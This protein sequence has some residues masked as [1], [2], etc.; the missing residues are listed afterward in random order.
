MNVEYFIAKRIHFQQGKKNVSRPAVRI[1]TIGIAL[2]LAVMLISVCVVIGFKSQI[3]NKIIGFG[4]HI[5][6]TNFDNN[7]TY[8]MNPIKMDAA[9]IQKIRQIPGVV[10]VQRFAT[11]PGIIK[12]D[13]EFQGIILK[14][15]DKDFDWNFFRSNLLEGNILNVGSDSL[16]NEILLSKKLSDLLGLKLGDELFMYFIQDQVRARKF[17]I[18]GIYSTNFVDYDQLFVLTDI[19][20]VQRLNNWDSASFGGLEVLIDNFDK[21]DERGEA[22]YGATANIFSKDG[23]AYY[24][25]TIKQLNPQIFS[26]LDLLDMNVW[27][28]LLLM[29][30][31]AGF[32][33]ISGLLIL[34][35][36]RTNMIGILKSL[37]ATNWSVRKIF[38]YHSFFLIA[39]G[40]FW[41]NL[42]GLSICALQYF[43][44][45]IPLDPE[46]YYV[47]SVPVAFPWGYIVLLNIGTFV[48][49]ILMMIAPSYLITKI[50]PA[51][52]I[53]YE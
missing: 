30:S 24:T 40:M 6:I 9:L 15:I 44:G 13:N 3:E 46:A 45:I 37:G 31:V 29:L 5:Q 23:N 16:K 51:K 20:H 47:A 12:T 10:H 39:K 32:N 34:I 43:T 33:M 17:K 14:G 35:L 28:I 19:R 8:E 38:L 11:K 7:N 53:R 41:G 36:E 48:A 1:A 25:Q 2:G 21:I 22:V 18:V 26:W 4:G 50:S 49:S 42:I 27:V 52:I